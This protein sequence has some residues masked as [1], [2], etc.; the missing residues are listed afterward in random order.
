MSKISNPKLEVE[1]GMNLNGKDY[2]TQLLSIVKAMEKNTTVFLTE[3][4][5]EKLFSK[6]DKIFN[7][8]KNLQRNI[9]ESMFRKGFYELEAVEEKKINEKLKTLN[10]DLES[11]DE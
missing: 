3:A 1:K 11:L 4:S 10:Q 2:M 6:I 9:F 5:N 7:S 8:Y